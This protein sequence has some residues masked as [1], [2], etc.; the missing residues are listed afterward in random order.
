MTTEDRVYNTI[1]GH[2]R[3]VDRVTPLEWALLD[4]IAATRAEGILQG[5][6][7]RQTKQNKHS[8][9]ARTNR[10]QA[11]G[12][13][14]KQPFMLGNTKT[15]R[16]VLRRYIDG[17]KGAYPL[18]QPPDDPR[19]PDQAEAAMSAEELESETSSPAP[20]STLATE[21]HTERTD[22]ANEKE[23]L[24]SDDGNI[25][26]AASSPVPKRRRVKQ[27]RRAIE[28][29]QFDFD[30][31]DVPSVTSV[32]S[33]KRHTKRKI[34]AKEV[35][36]NDSDHVKETKGARG[37]PR[38]F[39]RGTEK[40]WQW[41][42]W[43][44]KV[45][46]VEGDE[47]PT[48]RSGVMHDPA[49][50]A[51]FN[52]RPADFDQTLVDARS[53]NFPVPGM[54]Q[55]ISENWVK[56]TRLVLESRQPGAYATPTGVHVGKFLVR[57][58]IL[59][60]RSSRLEEL[61]FSNDKK[62]PRYRFIT[63]SLA[64][65]K[66]LLPTQEP[67]GRRGRKAKQEAVDAENIGTNVLFLTTS[68]AHTLR[69]YPPGRES[70]A[71]EISKRDV[72][73]EENDP[74]T[75]RGGPR[76]GVFR[77]ANI[78]PPTLSKSSKVAEEP[79]HMTAVEYR[80]LMD[81]TESDSDS[82]LPGKRSL[83]TIPSGRES[84]TS[85]SVG[86][87]DQHK[88]IKGDRDTK[89]Q[90]WDP[91][92]GKIALST[93]TA[94]RS[95]AQN[96]SITTGD[97]TNSVAFDLV[98]A[99]RSID[100]L[101]SPAPSKKR[102]LSL[103][104]TDD[105]GQP[106]PNPAKRQRIRT[107]NALELGRIIR[108]LIV[109]LLVAAGG[110]GPADPTIVSTSIAA[111]WQTTDA[112]DIPGRDVI[113]KI[114][115]SM[116][117]G[118]NLRKI[119]F[120][121]VALD[122]TF[123]QRPI[124]AL[125]STDPEGALVRGLKDKIRAADK[126]DYIPPEWQASSITSFPTP[127]RQTAVSKTQKRNRRKG[128]SLL[129]QSDGLAHNPET[130]QE[131]SQDSL[132]RDKQSLSF[133]SNTSDGPVASSRPDQRLR[134][135]SL[136]ESIS[137][138]DLG[139][140]VAT[141]GRSRR[142][143]K[144]TV[145]A[146]SIPVTEA[147]EDSSSDSE[148]EELGHEGFLTLKVPR[149]GIHLQ[150]QR[151]NAELRAL[152][153]ATRPV[154]VPD[155]VEEAASPAA[156]EASP[157]RR[158]RNRYYV[159][160]KNKDRR[161]EPKTLRPVWENL[162][163]YLH[164]TCL[165]DILEAQA[166]Y[167]LKL[168]PRP[169]GNPME[170][171]FDKVDIVWAWEERV[172]EDMDGI[173]HEGHMIN[174]V[175]VVD[176][177]LSAPLST[178]SLVSFSE[179]GEMAELEHPTFES[180]PRFVKALV[181]AAKP[182]IMPVELVKPA[183][184]PRRPRPRKERPAPKKRG[185]EEI[186]IDD[187]SIDDEEP[188]VTKR[189][190]R[191]TA[192]RRRRQSSDTSIDS[193]DAEF[194]VLRRTKNKTAQSARKP[195]LPILSDDEAYDLSLA[196]T[197][198][199]TLAGGIKKTIP[200]P[201]VQSLF[202]DMP[203]E[204]L[205]QYWQAICNVHYTKIQITA[206]HFQETYLSALENNEV[207][208][209]NFDNLTTTDWPTIITWAKSILLTAPP[210]PKQPE[211]PKIDFT[212]R[213]SL[214]STHTLTY[215]QRAPLHEV[216][217]TKTTASTWRREGVASTHV[218]GI[219]LLPTHSPAVPTPSDLSLARSAILSTLL[220]P[221]AHFSPHMAAARLTALAPDPT[222]SESLVRSALDSLIRDKLIVRRTKTAGEVGV[223]TY[224]VSDIFTSLFA[225]GV[226]VEMLRVANAYKVE[227]LDRA[228]G[229]AEVLRLGKERMMEDGEMVCLLGL[230]GRGL[231]TVRAGGDL[232]GGRYGVDWER[233]GY[234]VE[235]IGRLG[236]G[237]EVAIEMAEGYV[238][239]VGNDMMVGGE[240]PIGEEGRM[241]VWVGADGNVMKE[242]WEMILASV[243]GT[244]SLRPGSGVEEI[245]DGLGNAVGEWEVEM[246]LTWAQNNGFLRKTRRGKGFDTEDW[247]WT[248]VGKGEMQYNEQGFLAGQQR[249]TPSETEKRE[250]RPRAEPPRKSMSKEA[251]EAEVRLP[252]TKDSL[253]AGRMTGLQE[254]SL[255]STEADTAAVVGTRSGRRTKATLLADDDAGAMTDDDDDAYEDI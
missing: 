254:W 109:D 247:W 188:L 86:S 240:V 125:E 204:H 33:Q 36:Q 217:A 179:D 80:E 115:Q 62:A 92:P 130:S 121:V 198:I 103:I 84:R 19:E 197:V 108:Q 219:P 50:L 17:Q 30:D 164:A 189:P 119:Y 233:V 83:S 175:A 127:A 153:T 48:K 16:C 57:S 38:R 212:T 246:V 250:T 8:V 116:W 193:F 172:E 26:Y 118:G 69:Y 182:V 4:C 87:G 220:T 145:K 156:P 234:K 181:E 56:Q 82:A 79:P 243:L 105:C 214:L 23:Q 68:A 75:P 59:V 97:A 227:V 158:V 245:S 162:D 159:P 201:L 173:D 73:G 5:D 154:I 58:K 32:S 74:T 215:R 12:Y 167:D 13:I 133:A 137:S 224:C 139:V 229:R 113:K 209:I 123:H 237:F 144:P 210:P 205:Q 202:P 102:T 98:E 196:V 9:P 70:T 99:G 185:A 242:V 10:L 232:P 157:A 187:N 216:L 35:Y 199:R 163:G 249:Q 90:K 42:F 93:A 114:I 47:T 134:P 239:G 77:E 124:I 222:A 211:P 40:F 235:K 66:A 41:Q 174:H 128:V 18:P 253:V 251:Q 255:V 166:S 126:G 138:S 183:A 65:S 252:G 44:A 28:M 170:R 27:T 161:F 152:A 171:A 24:E 203:L 150:D 54:P 120:S 206:S 208:T 51:L 111:R 110:A 160:R 25:S 31:S 88:I 11:G 223:R 135:S 67:K 100:R 241:P 96:A 76:K 226:N 148:L 117:D 95:F 178:W 2:E 122:G 194:S 3:A 238:Y 236:V 131:Q 151:S 177:D 155:T 81:S 213:T 104:D 129:T 230:M 89:Q 231:V 190:E 195:T 106:L 101:S 29:D 52:A 248:C 165:Q 180:W 14:V 244:I 7:G 60:V 191:S 192:G 225:R 61:D 6:L 184:I 132:P 112:A 37:R 85:T 141:I 149:L 168:R 207:P 21:P 22:E 140:P 1:C 221:T 72:Q 63:S 53:V 71:P 91:P 64:H 46:A 146:T 200:W 55:E 39:L 94:H 169:H 143:R 15:S 107:T 136:Q 49:G 228:F 20:I 45:S 176:P 78:R 147:F 218:F 142:A 186:T 43:Q 34:Q